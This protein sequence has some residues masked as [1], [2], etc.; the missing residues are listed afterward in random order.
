MKRTL[1]LLMALCLTL[2]IGCNAPTAPDDI[3][4]VDPEASVIRIGG[5][6]GPTSIGM[7][8]MMDAA[9]QGTSARPYE[10]TLASTAHQL[11]PKLLQGELDMAAIPANLASILYQNTDGALCV[12]A[13]NTLGVLSIL[14][15]DG[16]AIQSFGDLRGKTI[17]A[18][19]QGTTP[20]YTLRYLLTEN[21]LNPDTDV[22]IVFCSEATEVVSYLASG[23]AEIA[24]LPQPF[25]TV[26]QIGRA[27]V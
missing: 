10:F 6:T 19:G 21:G 20:E 25:V 2:L 23:T 24:M 3:A 1:S 4:P 17:Y 8:S 11:T 14:E 12:L 9:A 7:V 15:K 18:T 13:V 26:A 22:T 27:H 16:E 5:P